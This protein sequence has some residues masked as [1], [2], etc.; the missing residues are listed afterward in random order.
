MATELGQTQVGKIKGF[1]SL[2]VYWKGSL[3]IPGD[4]GA[5]ETEMMPG[6]LVLPDAPSMRPSPRTQ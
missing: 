6:Y 3:T 4:R 5:R 2:S 1:W